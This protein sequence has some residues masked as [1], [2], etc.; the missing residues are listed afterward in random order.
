MKKILIGVPLFILLFSSVFGQIPSGYYDAATGLTGDNLRSALKNITKTGHVKLSY[1][2]VWNA[3][4]ITDVK[5][6]ADTV[7]WDMYTDIPGGTPVTTLVIHTGQCGTSGSHEGVCYSREHS[8]PNS[9]WGHL[10][11]AGHP[12][13]TDLHHLFPSDQYVNLHKSDHPL[14]QTNSP[15]YTS[16]NGSKIG[17]C[18]YTGY[19]GIVFEPRDEYKGDF[20]R[21]YLYMATRYMDSLGA[22]VKNFPLTEAKYVIDTTT[23]NYK[24]WFINMLLAWNNADTVSTKEINRNN[25]IYYNT[26]QHNRNPFVDHPEYVQAIWGGTNVI[27]QEPSNHVTN[28]LASNTSP[29]NSTITVTWTDASGNVIPDGYLIRASSVSF[30]QIQNPTD[31]ISESV[32]T[33][34]KLINQ[35]IQSATFTGLTSGTL[36]YFKIFPYTNCDNNINYKIDGTVPTV[37]IGTYGTIV[38]WQFGNPASAGNETTYNA[39][40][41]NANLNNSALSRGSGITAIALARGFSAKSWDVSA[42][43]T[44]AVTNNEYFQFTIN[45]K[46][47]YMISLSALDARLRR[48]S[49][50]APNAYIW[51]YS[52]DGTTFTEIGTDVSFTSIADG[53]TQSQIDLSG[54]SALQNVT[55]AKTLTFRIYAW[56]GT[57]TTATFA[58]ARYGAGI[59]T[60]CL[61][62]EGEVISAD[63]LWT[64]DASDN[65]WQTSNNWASGTPSASTNVLIPSGTVHVTSTQTSP[66]ICNNLT[67]NSGASL[68][69]DAG[70][71]L[72]VS[73][74]TILN[75]TGCLVIKSDATGTG[76]FIDNG[77]TGDG[78]ANVEKF[79]AVNT[80]GRTVA[81][82]LNNIDYSVFSDADTHYAKYYDPYTTNW[83]D[84]TSGNMISMKGYF[85]R[86]T[87]TDGTLAFNNGNLNTGTKTYTDLWRTGTGNGS[88]HGWNFIGNPYPS[89]INWDDVVTLNGGS[90]S[91]V[92]NTKLNNAIYVSDGNGGYNSYVVD[93]LGHGVGTPTNLIRIIPPATAFWVQ[94]NSSY[95]NASGKIADATLSFNNSVRVHQN[96]VSSKIASSQNIIRLSLSNNNFT[97]GLV[98]R[99]ENAATSLFDPEFDA[100]KMLADNMAYPQIYSMSL[101]DDMLSIN[102]ISN[103][104]TQPVAIQLGFKDVS[105]SML[106]I[107]ASDFTNID[108]GISVYL[109]DKL[110]NKLIDLR[111]QQSYAFNTSINEDNNRFVLLLNKA[112]DV[113]IYNYK[114]TVYVKSSDEHSVMLIYNMLGQ[115]ILKQ[116][117]YNSG[118]HKIN[119]NVPS[120][121]Y[122]VSVMS[123]QGSIIQKIFISN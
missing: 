17:P 72:T 121:S 22:W 59:I 107:K 110:L 36:Y 109:E 54:I 4:A 5:P 89:A 84:L 77:F 106:T 30:D 79:I 60:N 69:I 50:E 68:I 63:G 8:L 76:S 13:Y 67:V 31:G 66:A 56:G 100:F 83:L 86:F 95:I 97:D 73:G 55:Y 93:G 19:T 87:S 24:Q 42:T 88:N 123:P 94:V 2:N 64:G 37:S 18:S 45:A 111:Q 115:E 25:A 103:D 57:N 108:A 3:Y 20:A 33:S 120:G 12:Q 81:A 99:L 91:F 23:N 62:I 11:N 41:L 9:W 10:D 40:T 16:N 102:S 32:N 28:F 15:T 51:K 6:P 85:T 27:K 104:L 44:S 35:G 48:S 53:E 92:S 1:D 96:S 71:A 70:K 21:A 118:M 74:T 80:Y 122:L 82:P 26:A 119:V 117:L 47:G 38:A 49:T 101:D 113:L 34:Q 112:A 46:T 43:K 116:E 39:T 75:G 78:T 65:N 29:L 105:N 61:A 58:I 7:V 98:V 52:L 14:G 114:N 90:G